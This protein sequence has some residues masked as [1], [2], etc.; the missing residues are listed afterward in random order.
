MSKNPREMLNE[1]TSGVQAVSKTNGKEM[2]AFMN[3][4]GE[5]SKEGSIDVKTKE[6]IS[7]GIAVFSRCEYCIVCHAY[8]ALKAGATPEEIMEAAMVASGFGG[9]PTIAY[10]VTL[11]KD[12]LE[13]FKDDFKK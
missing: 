8:N 2:K 7:I 12:S 10:S 3:F 4:L 1:F 9:G 11:L 13:E 6:L 5:T